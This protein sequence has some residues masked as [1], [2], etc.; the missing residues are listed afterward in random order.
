MTVTREFGG[1]V[2]AAVMVLA[3]CGSGAVEG[4][5]DPETVPATSRDAGGGNNGEGDE[6]DFSLPKGDRSVSLN[7]AIAYDDL[8]QGKCDMVQTYLDGDPTVPYSSPAWKG[9][10][11]PRNVLLWQAGIHLCRGDTA[12]ARPWFDRAEEGY[13]WA[14]TGEFHACEL[15]KAAASAVRQRPKSDFTCQGGQAPPW[16]AD[17]P[18]GRDDPRTAVDE[19]NT[20]PSSGPAASPT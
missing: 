6:Y 1:A 17:G 8:Y 7:E 18:Y 4:P 16:L 10:L 12:A 2:L 14:G 15:Y 5:E 19:G 11:S 3:G 20:P 9:F 13:G